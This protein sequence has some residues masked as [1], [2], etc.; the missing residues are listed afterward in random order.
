MRSRASE[1]NKNNF[2]LVISDFTSSTVTDCHCDGVTHQL[3]HREV[4][5][6]KGILSTPLAMDVDNGPDTKRAK[7]DDDRQISVQFHTENGE[8]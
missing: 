5:T 8:K 2:F 4:R 6:Y 3:R 1:Q 7:S